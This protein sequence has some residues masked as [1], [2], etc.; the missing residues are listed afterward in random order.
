MKQ[1]WRGGGAGMRHYL[2]GNVLA[3]AKACGH[4]ALAVK[5]LAEPE[6]DQLMSRARP[7]PQNTTALLVPLAT[8]PPRYNCTG[9]TH[10]P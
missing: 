9:F 3:R 5:V 4:D 6:V 8:A 10:I 7:P 1:V 2:G